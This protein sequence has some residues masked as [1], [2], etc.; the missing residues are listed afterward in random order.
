MSEK[1]S[2]GNDGGAA[3]ATPPRVF[4][5]RLVLLRLSRSQRTHCTRLRRCRRFR[6]GRRLYDNSHA[7]Q[8][9]EDDLDNK[10]KRIREFR[11][12]KDRLGHA[13]MRSKKARRKRS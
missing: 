11:R 6:R 7:E 4:Q 13:V 8:N 3:F 5:A 2:Q 9:L 12:S 10:L 1:I